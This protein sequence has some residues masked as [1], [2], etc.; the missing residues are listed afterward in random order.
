MADQRQ[1]ERLMKRVHR[2]TQREEYW[3][4]TCRLARLWI[5]PE[6][7]E[8]YRP[9]VTLLL[10][11]DGKILSSR[12]LEHPPAAHDLFE[13]LLRAMRRPGL[14]AGRARRPTYIYLDN[15]DHVDALTPLLAALGI[16]CI[17]RPTLKVADEVMAAMEMQMGPDEPIPGL[18]S[19]PSVTPSLLGHLYELAAQVYQAAPWGWFHD[20]HPFAITCPP[21]RTP[22]Y[23]IVMG[24]GGEVFGLAVYDRLVDLQSMFTPPSSLSQM[25]KRSTWSVVFFEEAPAVSFDDLDAM[26]EN[27]WPVAAPDA[28]PVFGRA[29]SDQELELPTQSDLLWMEGALGALLTYMDDHM[30]VDGGWI[31]P[32]DLSLS[33]PRVGGETPVHLRLL[34]FD[35]IFDDNHEG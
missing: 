32:V 35:A 1:L 2:L 8:P 11:Q 25:A 4:A 22:R 3:V 19:V 15:I 9:Y 27:G 6:Q 28:Y 29:T 17:Y 7:E 13:E 23:A 31:Q 5:T 34:E 12:V 33:V 21:E 30:E 18:L 10:S 20:H 16:E 14:G 24:S 26:L